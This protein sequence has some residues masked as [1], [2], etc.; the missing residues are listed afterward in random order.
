MGDTS[1][2]PL[3]M[4]FNRIPEQLRASHA[5]EAAARRSADQMSEHLGEAGL[6][7]L[8]S[9]DVVHG[10]AEYCRQRPKPPA[11]HVDRMLQRVA[12]EAARMKRSSKD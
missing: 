5:A 12:D 3:G 1:H 10:F 2:W 8:R 4:P 6:E 11:A 7:L 9:V